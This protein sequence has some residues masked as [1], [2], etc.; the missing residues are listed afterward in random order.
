MWG[1][2]WFHSEAIQKPHLTWRQRRDVGYN[3]DKQISSDFIKQHLTTRYRL[4]TTGR[5]NVT[6][7]CCCRAHLTRCHRTTQHVV[8]M[9]FVKLKVNSLSLTERARMCVLAL[10]WV[11]YTCLWQVR[12]HER[13]LR[14][15]T[16][17]RV[18]Q[19][20]AST[21]TPARYRGPRIAHDV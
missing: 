6:C 12:L 13:M 9:A 16:V 1:S 7:T 14:F 10:W 17:Q 5:S 21:D 19:W 2:N 8:F 20:E 18:L 3:A 11:C 15:Q 4:T